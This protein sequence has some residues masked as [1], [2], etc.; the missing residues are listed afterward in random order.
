MQS[1]RK[2]NSVMTYEVVREVNGSRVEFGPAISF[3]VGKEGF[4]FLMGKLTPE[5]REQAAIH[6]I[7]Q[8]ISD[9]AAIGRD[10]ETGASA[11][12]EE[13][14]AAMK[15]CADRLMAGRAWDL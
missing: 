10:P 9:R 3:V 8:K 5:L 15:E 2:S 12:P 13:K 1:K 6:G 4:N 7:I 11:S 14:F